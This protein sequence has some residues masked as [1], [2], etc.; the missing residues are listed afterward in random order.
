MSEIEE[1]IFQ[2]EA[3]LRELGDRLATGLDGAKTATLKT[4]YE[5]VEAQL[6]GL[7]GEWDKVAS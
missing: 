2:L 6:S 1:E 5:A 3:E 7:Y 4:R